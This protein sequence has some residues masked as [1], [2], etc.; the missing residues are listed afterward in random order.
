M[1]ITPSIFICC[2]CLLFSCK[3]KDSAA[4]NRWKMQ[5]KMVEHHTLE[6][7]EEAEKIWD[8]LLSKRQEETIETKFLYTAIK[9]K[10]ELNKP[11]DIRKI[12]EI[13]E[14]DQLD[15]ICRYKILND[16]NQCKDKQ[17]EK[18]ENIDLQ[19]ELIR[20]LVVDQAYRGNYMKAKVEY[21]KFDSLEIMANLESDVDLVNRE[22]L[23]EIIS[24][25]GFPTKK[26]VGDE[27]M[28]SIFYIIQHADQDTAWQSEQLK[29][30]EKAVKSGD[31]D[32]NDYAYLYDRICTN[33]KRPQRYGT[34][35]KN[36]DLVAQIAELAETEDLENLDKRRR[37]ISLMPIDMY[38]RFMLQAR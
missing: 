13:A 36:V 37:E 27:G 31:M 24:T 2:L 22:R 19:I 23:Q 4:E 9:V 1:R 26:L 33:S 35:F 15:K 16:F 21:Y 25:H 3:S 14:T 17:I 7:Y 10:N 12:L 30:V 20:M 8:K 38:K 18:I 6:E 28:E 29:F 5:W 32:G 34:Q 11:K